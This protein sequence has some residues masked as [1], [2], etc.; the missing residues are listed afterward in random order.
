[1]QTLQ[2]LKVV[3]MG[4]PEFAVPT[5]Q[6]LLEQKIP[7]VGVVTG[8]D[9]PAGRGLHLQPT[10]VKKLA[11]NIGLPILQ[12]EKLRDPQFIENLRAWQAEVFVVVAF[13]ILP[14]EVFTIPPLG[15]VNIHAAL[16]PQYRGAAPI[17]WAIINGEH[18]TGV[19]TF[20]IEEKIDTGDMILQRKTAI[21]EFETAGELHDRLAVMGADLLVETLAQI[22]TDAVLRQPQVGQISLAPK[23][24]KEMAAIDWQKSARE[25]FNFIRGMNPVPGAFTIREGRNLKIFR[26]HVINDFSSGHEA[27]VVVRVNEHKGEFVVQAGMGHLAIDELQIEGKRRMSAAEFLR[28][29]QVITHK[30]LG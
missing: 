5:L 8:P 29:H 11:A 15:T 1:M 30:K 3:F 25:I 23:I 21:G 6:H 19:T 9:K 22:A 7:V 16:L 18:E 4:T 13:R 17:Q 10:P 24:T 26:T 14:P 2:E 28:G 27:G 12:P 20:F